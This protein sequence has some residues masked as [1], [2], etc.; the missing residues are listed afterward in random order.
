MKCFPEMYYSFPK[1]VLADAFCEHNDLAVNLQL[2]ISKVLI[3]NH[4]PIGCATETSV[5]SR[6][7]YSLESSID[8]IEFDRETVFHFL[9]FTASDLHTQTYESV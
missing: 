6:E 7:E 8:Q 5:T 2:S 9:S 1:T 4:R 3:Q